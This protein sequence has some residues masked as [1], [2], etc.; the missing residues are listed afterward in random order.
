M[1][2]IALTIENN[3]RSTEKELE[4]IYTYHETEYMDGYVFTP[5][6]IEIEEVI[7]NGVNIEKRL[8]DNYINKLEGLVFEVLEK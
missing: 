2:A 3:F 4:V 5:E 6:Y 8:S 7:I 1:S